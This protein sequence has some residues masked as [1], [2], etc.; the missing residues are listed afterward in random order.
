MGLLAIVGGAVYGFVYYVWLK[1]LQDDE[2]FVEEEGV[3]NGGN[4]SAPE[5]K[6]LMVEC[7]ETQKIKTIK[8]PLYKDQSTMVSFERLSLMIEYN[9]IGSLTSLGRRSIKEGDTVI[10]TSIP[11][12]RRGSYSI[13]MFKTSR[14]SASKVDLLKSAIEV[15]QLRNFNNTSNCQLNNSNNKVCSM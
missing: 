11:S 3:D 1:E 5:N 8:E 12:I 14:G 6:L 9:Q 10:R 7:G 4:K 2:E 15:N 13:G